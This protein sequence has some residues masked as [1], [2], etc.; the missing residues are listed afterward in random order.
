MNCELNKNIYVSVIEIPSVLNK[1][2]SHTIN[3]S[4]SEK[5]NQRIAICDTDVLKCT[6][7]NKDTIVYDLKSYNETKLSKF[8]F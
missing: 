4:N 1:K 5:V 8:C 6:D 7:K 2:G 3:N